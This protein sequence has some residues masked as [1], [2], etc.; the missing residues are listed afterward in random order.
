MRKNATKLCGYGGTN[1]QVVRKITVKCKFLDA[2][3]LHR[4]D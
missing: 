4:E 2:K 1:I 3:V